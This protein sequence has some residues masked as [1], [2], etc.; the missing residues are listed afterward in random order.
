[1]KIA[2]IV[3][4]AQTGADRGGLEAAIYCSLPYG[5]WI[6]KGRNAEDGSIPDK[7]EGLQETKSADYP[8]RT[9]ANVVDSDATLVLCYGTPTGG[10]LKTVEFA[11]KHRRPCLCVDLDKPRQ[12]VVMKVVEWLQDIQEPSEGVLNVAGSRES[13]SRGIEWTVTVRLVDVVSKV[14][15]RMFYPLAEEG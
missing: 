12:E 1:M 14:N 3:S 9:E 7:Y 15:G 6:P 11:A 4:G 13:K 10:S 2:K 5:G 8:K